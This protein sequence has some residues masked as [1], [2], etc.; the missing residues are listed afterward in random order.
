VLR[1]GGGKA[2]TKQPSDENALK[3]HPLIEEANKV[4][5]NA[6]VVCDVQSS[7]EL[8]EKL[9]VTPIGT[10]MK[11]KANELGKIVAELYDLEDCVESEKPVKI[12]LDLDLYQME[13]V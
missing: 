6:L 3:C 8:E 1:F 5:G 10:E 2:L 4:K 11:S 9:E 13:K 12:N 7:P